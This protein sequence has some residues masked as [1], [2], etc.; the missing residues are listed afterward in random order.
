MFN[1]KQR[2]LDF[3]GR[4][5]G[6]GILA[7]CVL[8]GLSMCFYWPKQFRAGVFNR[9]GAIGSIQQENANDIQIF[10]EYSNTHLKCGDNKIIKLDSQG[11]VRCQEQDKL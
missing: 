4:C 11:Y 3:I 1:F 8:F 7:V 6:C 10:K 5:M 9:L 2:T